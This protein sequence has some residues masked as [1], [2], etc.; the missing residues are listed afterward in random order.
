M[1]RGLFFITLLALIW[2]VP[3]MLTAKLAERRGYSFPAFFLAALFL[4]WP[5]VLLVTL[6]LPTRARDR[7][8]E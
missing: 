5:A 1:L 7:N 8:R 6:V 3:A 4:F 2:I